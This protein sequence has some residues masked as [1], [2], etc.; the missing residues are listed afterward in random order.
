MSKKDY[1]MVAMVLAAWRDEYPEAVEQ[2]T[3]DMVVAFKMGNPAFNQAKFRDAVKVGPTLR[4]ARPP[5]ESA[6]A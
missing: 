3:G 6:D 4:Q 5:W 2:I 1:A